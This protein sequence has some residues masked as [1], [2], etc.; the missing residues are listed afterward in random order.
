MTELRY[1]LHPASVSIRK[2]RFALLDVSE[3]RPTMRIDAIDVKIFWLCIP[4]KNV[5]LYQDRFAGSL[6]ATSP[7]TNPT[8]ATSTS[9]WKATP[10]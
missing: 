10:R 3:I 2:Q 6:T 7:D 1:T 5:V 8:R 4:L 9:S